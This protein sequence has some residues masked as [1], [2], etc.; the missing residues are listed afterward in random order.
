MSGGGGE[1]GVVVVVF[2][3]G[4]DGG[5]SYAIHKILKGDTLTGFVH[6]V[7]EAVVESVC[8][9]G[10]SGLSSIDQNFRTSSAA[11]KCPESFS[12]LHTYQIL[13]I[14]SVPL[15]IVHGESVLIC[16]FSGISIA[17]S[18]MLELTLLSPLLRPRI[19]R[20]A[21]RQVGR[22][23]LGAEL[24]VRVDDE[25]LPVVEHLLGHVAVFV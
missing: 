14:L 24:V 25:V 8:V 1:A 5:V 23:I 20:I 12:I 21:P 6:P 3:L 16:N 18:P 7:L 17:N 13:S 11:R 2:G 4:R 9:A 15:A 10:A 19:Q 22:T